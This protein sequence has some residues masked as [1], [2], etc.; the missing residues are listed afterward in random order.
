M[1]SVNIQEFL[2]L[3][4]SVQYIHKIDTT[5]DYSDKPRPCH[6][7]VFMLDGVAEIESDGEKFL[8]ERNEVLFVPKNTIYKA[9]W[10]ASPTVKF[11]S[12][13]F[14]FRSGIDPLDKKI[15]PVQKIEV[16]DFNKLLN[17][18]KNIEKRQFYKDEQVFLLLSDFYKLCGEVFK[19]VQINSKQKHNNII[20][21]AV[22]YI[23]KN[24]YRELTVEKLSSLVFLSPSRF[25]YL[26][27]LQTGL[28][29]IAYKNKIAVQN[30][31]QELLAFPDKSVAQI[32]FSHGFKGVIYFER[33]FKKLTGKTPSQYRKEESL[34]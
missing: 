20:A 14:S 3:L 15:I 21:T 25:Y 29:P 23:E 12:V 24:Y 10:K 8:L 27:K 13:H 5:Y 17:I 4:L 16:D 32:A 30:A 2:N 6:N 11:H 19:K 34:L 31:S 22:S 26:F 33:L 18:A 28:S 1:I 7:L 9:I